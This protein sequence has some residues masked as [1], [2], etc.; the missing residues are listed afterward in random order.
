MGV[1]NIVQVSLWPTE[2]GLLWLLASLLKSDMNNHVLKTYVSRG[3]MKPDDLNW[4]FM[5]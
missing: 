1:V 5:C 3:K 4:A 2:S